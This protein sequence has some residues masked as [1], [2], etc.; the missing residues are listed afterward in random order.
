VGASG[1]RLRSRLAGAAALLLAGAVLYFDLGMHRGLVLSNDVRSAVWPWA[2]LARERAIRT[3]ALSDPVWQFVPWLRLARRELA[4]GRLPLWNPHQD[5]GVPLLG[6]A[7]S[8][9]G[10]PLVWPALALGIDRGW[11]LSLLARL[12]VALAC[13]FLWLREL[14][15]TRAS[16]ALGAA[17]FALSGAFVAWLEHPQTLSA[18]A[19]PLLLLYA[20]RAARD[21]APGA[22]A[23]VAL[24]TSAVLSGGHPETQL[25][26]AILAGVAVVA[27][28]PTARGLFAPAAGGTLGAGLAAPVLLPFLDYFRHSAARFGQGRR[29]FV[30]PVRELARLAVP[31]RSGSNV[32]E[33]AALVSIPLLLVLPLGLAAARRDRETRIWAI[34]AGAMLLAV[35]ENPASRLLALGTP[36]YWTRLL[37]FLPL[38]LAAV[39]SAGLDLAR[40]WLAARFGAVR[41]GAA[42]WAIAAAGVL[43]LLAG[44]R[45]VHG[46]TPRESGPPATPLLSRLAQDRDVFRILPLHT[47]LP[48]DSATDY[49]L[50]D[51][52]GYDA[53]ASA[54][55]RAQR[56]RIGRF[57]DLPTHRDAIEPWDLTPGGEALD[58]WNV[59]YLMV[60]P[61]FNFPASLLHERFGLDVEEVYSGPDGRLFRNRRVRPRVTLD[62]GGEMRILERSPGLWT[63]AVDTPAGASLTL[64]DPFFPGWT[65]RID[66]ARAALG[67][68][69]GD[70]MRLPVPGGRHEVRFEY[71]PA[72]FA[73]G[74]G[75]A[76]ASAAV[77]AFLVARS[78]KRAL[79]ATAA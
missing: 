62:R 41:A 53:L 74:V 65:A 68:R 30:L 50:D 47:F 76:L 73:G 9:L 67:A 39:G 61:R 72:S 8:A 35:Y 6:N 32:I 24:S 25:M 75:L 33:A 15:R 57:R 78:R 17:A 4:A 40:E 51:V 26:A 77:L 49:G 20:R 48:P 1:R 23:G 37:L 44:A 3:P 60:D 7:Q 2:G 21:P 29:P 70:P 22:V 45:G 55:W 58:A 28:S 64:A 31:F 69:P 18:A 66:G 79:P 16:S 5:G 36:I 19:V 13:A 10:S 71:R 27:S 52:R 34:A 42:V 56:E 54:G 46:V 12:L 59:K 14:G 63:V 43:Q 11:N 38:A